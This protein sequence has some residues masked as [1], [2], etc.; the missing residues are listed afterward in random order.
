MNHGVALFADVPRYG[1]DLAPQEQ[2]TVWNVVGI[3]LIWR[4]RKQRG[5]TTLG[6]R[7]I[8]ATSDMDSVTHDDIDVVLNPHGVLAG[9]RR[10]RTVRQGGHPKRRKLNH[11]TF[12]K[13]WLALS[14]GL[15]VADRRHD[16]Q[17]RASAK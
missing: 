13:T 7:T 15:T 3:V 2:R 12:R 4:R 5:K 9:V 1:S 14:V 11:C 10:L 6:I 17:L 16:R 8:D